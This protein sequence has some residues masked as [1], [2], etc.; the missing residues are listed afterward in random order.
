M[1][2]EAPVR[3]GR[4]RRSIQSTLKRGKDFVEAFI[5]PTVSYAVFVER[6]TKP[7]I[8]RPVYARYLRFEVAGRIV[9]AR[10]VHHPGTRPNPFVRRTAE[11]VRQKLREGIKMEVSA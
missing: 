11:I 10:E 3:T 1:Q 8:I 4:L 6:G 2:Q 9:F 5:G 7:H